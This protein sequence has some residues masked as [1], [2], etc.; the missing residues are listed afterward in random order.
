MCTNKALRTR[1]TKKCPSKNRSHECDPPH[2]TPYSE[3]IN[4]H[5]P[6][7]DG[8]NGAWLTIQRSARGE[9]SSNFHKDHARLLRSFALLWSKCWGGNNLFFSRSVTHILVWP[10]CRTREKIILKS[11]NNNRK[12]TAR[13]GRFAHLNL[14]DERLHDGWLARITILKHLSLQSTRLKERWSMLKC[15]GFERDLWTSGS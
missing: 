15:F 8:T 1:F 7:R 3:A 13:W 5:G 12:V 6:T 14:L 10:S 11:K 9:T 4:P 2:S